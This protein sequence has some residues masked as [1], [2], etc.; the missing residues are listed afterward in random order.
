M[1]KWFRSEPMEYISIIMNEDAAHD[2]LA[3]LGKLGAIQF[4]DLNPDLTPFQ[5]RYVSYVKRCDELERKLR[6]FSGEIDKFELEVAPAGTIDSFLMT[7][8]IV[9]G[10]GGAS[11]GGTQLLESLEGELEGYES[12]LRE[13]N[14]YSEKLT[15]EYNEKIELQEVLEKARRFFMTDGTRLAVS[16]LSAGNS[17][18]PSNQENLLDAEGLGARPDLDMRF[19]SIT[20]VVS[21]E[22]KARFER[23]IFRA[24]R[25]N[26]YVR[27]A[28]IKQP[29]T[30]PET[31]M[32]LEKSVFIIFYKSESIE[33]KLKKICD[34]FSAHR[35]SLPDMDDAA[36]VDQM[37]TE[38]AQELV[39]SR[40]VLLKNQDTRYR[41]CQ[42]L[43]KHCE[44]W[45]WIVLKEKA[46]YHSLNMFKADVSGMLR[47]E[48]WVVSES[49]SDVREAVEKAHANMDM[50]MPSLVDHVP[51][52]WPTPPTHFVTNKFT[53]GYQEFVNTYGI[54]RYREANPALFTAATF[55]FLF[56]V[57]Y[58]DIGHGLFLFCAGLFLIWKEKE[59]DSVKLSEMAEGLHMGR[60]MIAMMG[61]FAVYAGLIYNDC[62]SLGINF[63]GTRW[64]FEGQ[65]YGAVEEGAIATLKDQYGS[66]ESVYPFGLDPIWHVTSNELL[67]FNSFKMKLS[68]IFGIFQMFAGTCLKG[69]NAIY[70]GEKLD[71]LFEFIPMVV[72]ATSLFLYMVFLIFFKW[73]VDWN[74]RMLS[75]TCFD[76]YND[77]AWGSSDYD[78]EWV[79]CDQS[80]N[81]Y[82]TPW[83]Y[84]CQDG[85]DTATKCPL[86]YG[87]SGDGCQPPNL[88]TTLINIALQ[89]GTVDEPMYYGQPGIQNLLLLCAFAS[90][91]IL[92][93]AKPYLLS[94][95]THEQIHHHT[96]DDEG[97]GDEE[98][99]EHGFGEILIHQAIETIE[100]VLGMVS[101]TA[102]YL[103][104]W[105]LSLA[106][107]ELATVFWEKAMLSGLNSN[108]FAAYIGFGVFAG[109]TFGVLLMMDVLEC[110]LHALRLHWVEFQNK[111][112][113]A[114]GVRFSP[115]SF[116]QIIKDAS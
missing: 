57:M 62:F 37:L 111:F 87:G 23:M 102:S 100:F 43:A 103:R 48:G 13:L 65:E 91:P 88:I 11:K 75:A 58:G 53:Y 107:S 7:P 34:A 26:C 69:L 38:N 32:L 44:R 104:L 9:S 81:G 24:T 55:P 76:P 79:I 109:V 27:F 36:S 28:P 97:H 33:M 114:D 49:L 61:F 74:S 21:T 66:A 17:V 42:M 30:D 73:T 95:Q 2:C 45:T 60:Y 93:L 106:H 86:D 12:Q 8:A 105:A 101:N 10:A 110:F 96:D 16:E 46:V 67:F 5:R 112:F 98:E 108:F 90:V 50:A 70:F 4:T 89:P 68:V 82:C 35:Y 54:P 3:D 113:K 84:S 94:Q 56:G 1:S 15:I 71:F 29:I 40:T 115:Y 85:D 83:G 77:E 39:D 64:E 18:G 20:G 59:N 72:F 116:K 31:G 6:F 41:L 47:G 14:S 80:G 22:E 52:P 19:S 63:F 25:G 92:L 78:G 99:D 51:Q